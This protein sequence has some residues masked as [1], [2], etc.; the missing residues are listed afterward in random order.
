[1]GK[2]TESELSRARKHYKRDLHDGDILDPRYWK[3]NLTYIEYRSARKYH[4][5]NK[6]RC[7]LTKTLRKRI[8]ER[9]GNRCLNCGSTD[10]LSIDHIIPLSKGGKTIIQNL[11]TLCLTCN[12]RKGNRI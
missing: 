5:Y 12:L 6:E 4:V 7:I 3:Q 8:Y 10:N 11:Q 1:M 2:Y 9:D